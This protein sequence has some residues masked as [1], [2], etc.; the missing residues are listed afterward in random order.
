MKEVPLLFHISGL[1]ETTNNLLISRIAL[2]L[3]GIF[4]WYETMNNKSI[5]EGIV[6]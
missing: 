4:L 6:Y 5:I 1:L 2:C 3:V